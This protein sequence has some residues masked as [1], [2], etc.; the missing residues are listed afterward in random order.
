MNEPTKPTRADNQAPL[1]IA[2]LAALMAVLIAGIWSLWGPSPYDRW[3][4]VVFP[5]VLVLGMLRSLVRKPWSRRREGA[6]VMTI[7]NDPAVEERPRLSAAL[8]A[9]GVCGLLVF[10]LLMS[11]WLAAEEQWVRLTAL[12]PMTLAVAGFALLRLKVLI[13]PA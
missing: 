12:T 9:L 6:A 10:L 11:R 7:L 13:R 8:D 1:R 4:Y 5:V 2:G 3:Q